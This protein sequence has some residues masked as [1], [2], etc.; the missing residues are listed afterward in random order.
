[1]SYL[2]KVEAQK[3]LKE[4]GL[5]PAWSEYIP[6]SVQYIHEVKNWVAEMKKNKDSINPTAELLEKIRKDAKQRNT[7]NPED[8]EGKPLTDNSQSAPDTEGKEI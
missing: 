7:D 3:L 1:M 4:A 2:L 6:D 8:T 5:N